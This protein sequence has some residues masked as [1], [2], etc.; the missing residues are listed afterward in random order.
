MTD[1]ATAALP[2]DPRDGGDVE[3]LALIDR[4][5]GLLERSDPKV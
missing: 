4:L 3:L 2:P 1:E 5:A